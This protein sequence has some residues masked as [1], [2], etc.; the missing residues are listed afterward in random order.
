MHERLIETPRFTVERRRYRHTDG[1]ELIRD[2]VVHPGAVVVLAMI[3]KKNADQ[4]VGKRLQD[5]I[6]M[7]RQLRRSVEKT[8]LELPAG[9]REPDEPPIETARRELIE[10]TGF[11]AGQMEPLAT[12]YTSPGITTE[13]MHAFVATELTEVGQNLERGEEIEVETI[14]VKRAR[15]MLTCGEL[16]DGKTIAVLG[17]YFAKLGCM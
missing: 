11:Q 16:C 5:R 2:V 14:D 13:L 1:G 10:E 9:T 17:M 15:A 4:H 12:F 6:V 3:K 8:L 7:I